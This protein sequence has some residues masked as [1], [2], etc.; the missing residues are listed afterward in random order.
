[1]ET[2]HLIG[3]EQVERAAH[4]MGGAAEAMLRAALN[5]DNA[6]DRLIRALDDAVARFERAAE[7][8]AAASPGTEG[9]ANGN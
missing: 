9:K 5:M 2:I 7:V 1:M 4:A 6:A 8:F 3:A